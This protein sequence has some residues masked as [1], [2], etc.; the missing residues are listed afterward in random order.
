MSWYYG[1]YS[2]G[3]KGRVNIIGPVKDRQWKAD[4]KFSKMCP[5]CWEKHLEKERERKNKEAEEKAKEMELP[6][7]TGSERQ[8][9]WAN[10]L[11]QNLIDNLTNLAED[12]R[13]MKDITELYDIGCRLNKD[14]V[15]QFMHYIISS[16]AAARFYIDN[17]SLSMG[18]YIEKY[19]QEAFKS[20][21]EKYEEKL[22]EEEKTNSAVYPENKITDVP[23]EIEVIEDTIEVKFEKNYDFI[24]IVKDLEYRWSGSVWYRKIDYT[25][26]TIEDRVAELGNKLLNE[27]FPV[28]ILDEETRN[29]AIEG[30][31]EQECTRWIYVRSN[32]KYEGRFAIKWR[33]RDNSLYNN[34][35]KLPGSK[36]DSAVMV[37]IEHY[38]EVEEFAE[39]YGFKFSKGAIK[40]IEEYKEK[41]KKVE[42]IK[43]VKVEEEEI[44]DGLKEILESSTEIL[45]DLKDD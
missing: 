2:C 31:Y 4:R 18:R 30:N 21:E 14:K 36:W 15:L 42:V 39:L 11:R 6:E 38:K 40:A 28:I 1:T 13:E 45:D 25:N 20:D 33:G 22:L 19:A 37:R 12:K 34:A 3:H 24:A 10:T 8:I 29:K 44:K 41:L 17:R 9:A 43:P 32:G 23:A 27:G 26:G 35:R 5:E 7:L 16:K